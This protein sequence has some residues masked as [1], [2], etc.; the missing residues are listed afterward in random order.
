MARTIPPDAQPDSGRTL[1]FL[2]RESSLLMRRRFLH[3]ARRAGLSVNRSAA[4][5]LL[6]VQDEPGI[7]QARVASLLDVETISVVRLVDGLEQGGLLERRP[8]ATD[9]RVRTLWLTDAGEDAA[10][11]IRDIIRVVRGEALRGLPADRLDDLLD[12]L[13][14]IRDNLHAVSEAPEAEAML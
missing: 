2:L 7:N 6:R 5:L 12:A 3:Y 9:R 13:L 10:V 14:A 8:H 11:K 1:V 4:S